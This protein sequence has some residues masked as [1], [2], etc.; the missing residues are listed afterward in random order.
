MFLYRV[1]YRQIDM[2]SPLRNWRRHRQLMAISWLQVIT[3]PNLD[4]LI[5][6]ELG[7]SNKLMFAILP[8]VAMEAT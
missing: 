4:N 2:T 8:T 6:T 3:W 1:Q 5:W 7:V